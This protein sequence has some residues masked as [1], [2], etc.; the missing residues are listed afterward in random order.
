MDVHW[1][2][3]VA[4]LVAFSLLPLGVDFLRFAFP[5]WNFSRVVGRAA[6]TFLFIVVTGLILIIIRFH[7][8]VYL[9]LILNGG[10][11]F[12]STEG[13]LHVIFSSWLWINVLGNYYHTIFLHPGRDE[14]FSSKRMRFE[15]AKIAWYDIY[16]EPS[17]AVYNNKDEDFEQTTPKK[18]RNAV[19][20]T[21]VEWTPARSHF[22]GVCRCAVSYWDH[23]CPFTGNCIGL[24]NY[25][26]FFVGLCYG[27]MGS[28]YAIALTWPYFYNCNIKPL[29]PGEYI[30]EKVCMDLGANSYIFLPVFVG[31][32]L[33]F[34]MV[35]LNCVLLLADLS[36][37][38]VQKHWGRYP[39]VKFIVQR[40]CAK[41]F[42]AKNSRL[43]V[44]I[45]KR[46]KCLL[47]Y[48]LPFR[49]P[50]LCV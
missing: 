30:Q 12:D 18:H 8:S 2:L 45:L 6:H 1:F 26:N 33:S 24:R 14:A 15:E 11:P 16:V 47:L 7:H 37:Y 35:L 5:H 19:P 25:S 9:P 32:W 39:M 22:C 38:D 48:L 29:F 21:G 40:I 28:V 41:K 31:F 42:L 4:L 17:P 50:D 43:R 27:V 34:C 20:Q 44:L 3:I 49:N 23:H 46:R 13:V 36:T 10:N